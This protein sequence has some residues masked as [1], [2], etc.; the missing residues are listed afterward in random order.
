[1]CKPEV[2]APAGNLEK[3]KTAIAYGADAV[4]M[5]GKQ[6]GLRTFSDNFTHEEM[7]EG[8]EY[9]H[10]RGVKCYCTVNVMAHE[11]DISLIDDEIRFL[12][13]VGMDALIIS[14]AGIF[15]KVRRIAPNMEIHISTQASVTNSEGCM[16][17]YEQGAKRVVLA[18]ELTL[19]EIRKIRSAVP[20]DLELECFVHGA[21]CVSYSGRCLLSSYFTGRSANSG[22]CAQPCRWGYHLVEEKRP[23]DQ[24][25]IVEDER[26]TYVLSS[27]DICMISHIP[28][29]IAAGISSFKIEGRI[30]GAF[31]AASVAKAYREAVDL[32][33]QSPDA[34]LEDERW[35]TMLNR[36]V[37]REFATGF[38]FDKPMENAQIFPEKTYHRPAFVVGVVTGYDAQKG[39]AIVSQRNKIFQGDTL[40]VLM[41]EG[42]CEPIVA[43]ELWDEEMNPIDSTPH[44]EMVYYLKVDKELPAYTFLSRDGDKDEGIQRQS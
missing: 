40:H 43:T 37:H 3:L 8:V 28:E 7:R 25:P 42:Y 34:Y 13:E 5:A 26:G 23:E 15:R 22:S 41:P 14:D 9:A 20:A 17:W 12:S 10:A 44:S 31:Y 19:D 32:Y 4:Y 30:K 33:M 21:M 1:M 27:K 24:F 36:T 29:L 35:Q 18:R 16:F 38:Y 6:F 11:A 39:C 2:L